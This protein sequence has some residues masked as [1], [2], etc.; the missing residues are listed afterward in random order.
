MIPAINTVILTNYERA[1]LGRIIHM[2]TR[3]CSGTQT[4]KQA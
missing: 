3:T 2:L 1:A 4:N